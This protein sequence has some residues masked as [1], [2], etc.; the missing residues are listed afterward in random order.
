MINIKDL[1]DSAIEANKEAYIEA[2]SDFVYWDECD[3]TQCSKESKIRRQGYADC[4]FYTFNAIKDS[5]IRMFP[6]HTTY[7]EDAF[8]KLR[9]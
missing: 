5:V 2:Y 4:E 7:I 8:Y 3:K 9:Q 6:E 1:V